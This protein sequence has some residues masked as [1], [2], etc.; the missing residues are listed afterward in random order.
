MA[1]TSTLGTIEVRHELCHGC[2]ACE[3]ACS[4][5]CEGSVMPSASRIRV[6]QVD[7]GPLDIPV[8]CRQCADYPCVAACPPRVGALEVDRRTGAVLPDGE[9]CLGEKCG[10]CAR[11]CPQQSAVFF[12]PVTGKASVCDLCGGQPACV[13]A[14]PTGALS[15]IPGS[16]FD[17]RHGAAPAG[18]L[19]ADLA[20]RLFGQ[21]AD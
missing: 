16:S 21:N 7:P 14:C 8:L 6:Y 13:G 10:R 5:R 17:G 19:A 15:F 1:K 20:L 4:I 2:R 3:I 11:A 9:K 18:D 12:H